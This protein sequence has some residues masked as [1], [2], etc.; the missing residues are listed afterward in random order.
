KIA[1]NKN[2]V[3]VINGSDGVTIQGN[4]IGTNFS[5]TVI[6]LIKGLV[7]NFQP[8]LG[9]K[10]NDG[11]AEDGILVE[12]SKNIFV[13]TPAQNAANLISHNRHGVSITKGS[14]NV[15]IQNNLIGTQAAN[16]PTKYD[17]GNQDDGVFIDASTNVLI[18]GTGPLNANIIAMNLDGIQVSG[19][20]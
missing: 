20:S 2:G 12:G 16:A 1:L 10:T 19:G 11:Q 5:G 15:V 18:G 4:F 9:G 6:P 17:L 13:G 8:S 7:E 3:H 14:S